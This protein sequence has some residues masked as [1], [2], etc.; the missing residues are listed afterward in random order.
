[1]TRLR[2]QQLDTRKSFSARSKPFLRICAVMA[3]G[4]PSM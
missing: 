4:T 1:L 2:S 3:A